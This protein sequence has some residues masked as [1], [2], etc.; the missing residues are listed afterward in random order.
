MRESQRVVEKRKNHRRGKSLLPLLSQDA[1]LLCP[2]GLRSSLAPPSFYLQS[3]FCPADS[4]SNS[5]MTTG[6]FF[7]PCRIQH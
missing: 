3:E 4:F 2:R 1:R 6:M 5:V 7:S